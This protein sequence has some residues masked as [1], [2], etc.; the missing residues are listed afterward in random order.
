[1]YLISRANAEKEPKSAASSETSTDSF[2]SGT[3]DLLKNEHAR[4]RMTEISLT[5][6]TQHDFFPS[7]SDLIT[8]VGPETEVHHAESL[9]ALE[10]QCSG[11]KTPFRLIAFCTDVIVPPSLL[12]QFKGGAYNFHPGP[13]TYP[14]IFPSCFAIYEGVKEFGSTCHRMTEEI[15]T[16]EIVGTN[17]F[18]I[19][20]DVDRFGLDQL[21]LK[22][23]MGL[24]ESLAPEIVQESGLL[25]P[26]G[27][28]WQG[29]PR[30]RKDFNALCDLP[31]DIDQ[32]EFERRYRAVGEGPYHALSFRRFG[33]RFTL[34]NI[35][36][37]K[38]VYR[39]GKP[40]A[41]A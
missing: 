39:G 22:S 24:F 2:P 5:I 37:D 8:K 20:D 15:D 19:P 12:S 28:T 18:P 26:T 13:R 4:S 3:L 10:E 1:M 36:D 6:L 23:V 40:T 33:H 31:D 35:R 38:A 17:S 29:P 7:L 41:Q 34:N 14:G 32:T 16:G 21:S 25:T 30:T 9:K 11:P 27:E